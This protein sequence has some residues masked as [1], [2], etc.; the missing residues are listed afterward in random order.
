MRYPNRIFFALGLWLASSV[1]ALAACPAGWTGF[2]T[3]AA[4]ASGDVTSALGFTPAN[5][6]G[7][8]FTGPLI[9]KATA[10]GASG[11]NLPPGTAPTSPNNGDVW[12]TSAGI[13][14]Q[15]N[16]STIGPLLSGLV[17]LSTGVTGNLPVGNLNSGTG[18]SNT[19]FW[20]GDGTW[21][22]P[23]GTS[24]VS[25]TA[26]DGSIVVSPSPITGIGTITAGLVPIAK[27]GTN[28]A[29]A[30]AALANLK[31][32]N[33]VGVNDAADAAG[34]TDQYITFSALTA[35]RTVTLPDGT[36]C[37]DGTTITVADDLGL[38]TGTNTIV[39][40]P[41]GSTQTIGQ[42]NFGAGGTVTLSSGAAHP[43][44]TFKLDASSSPV[45]WQPSIGVAPFAASANNFLTG[46][47]SAGA[48]TQAQ[49]SFANISGQAAISQI[50]SAGLSATAPLNIA[51][52]G[53]ITGTYGTAANQIVEGGVITAGG[54]TG[55]ATVTPVLTY[56]AAGQ[57][58]A[59]TTVTIA[60]PFSAVTGT[61]TTLSGYG[62]TNGQIGP[63][64]GDVTTSGAASTLAT[65]NSNVGSFTSAN[66]TVNAKGLVTA[67]AN[68]SG[69]GSGGGWF[70][71][72]SNAVVGTATAGNFFVPIGGG[73]IGSATEAS[74]DVGAP[75]ATTV[76]KLSVGVATAPGASNS[77]TI[78]LRDGASSQVLTC[79]IS[80]ASAVSCVDNTHSFN[81][82]AGDLVDWEITTVGTVG[83]PATN[84]FTIAA[85]NGT[86][87]VGVT[88]AS[89]TSPINVASPTTTPVISCATC[90]IGPG[91]ST[92]NNVPQ[93]NS[94]DGVTLKGGVPASVNVNGVACSLGTAACTPG[95]AAYQASTWYTPLTYGG[96][97]GGGTVFVTT[98]TYCSPGFLPPI[99]V[100]A[101]GA[102]VF[103]LSSGGHFGIAIYANGSN[104][105][106]NGAPLAATN[107]TGILTTN[108][109][110][111]SQALSSPSTVS[112]SGGMIW[113]C[114]QMDN[115]T[116]KLVGIANG[117]GLAGVIGSA[118]IGSVVGNGNTTSI[119]D[120]FL[121][122]TT[123]GTWPTFTSGTS[124]TEET[125]SGAAH[126]VSALLEVSSEP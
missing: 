10:I 72:S 26:A 44:A 103:T 114:S 62:I 54:P 41:N 5:K 55:S 105:R 17:S 37:N 35:S 116:A 12:T 77:Y 23:A 109:V 7:D 111:I 124:W 33:R 94:S 69:G 57:I 119:V 60:P 74:V 14:V 32:Q 65:V 125:G 25:I 20:R 81:V 39:I 29:T 58:T 53:A 51:S 126:A 108:A 120:V 95:F 11:F 68:G 61:P 110:A 98:N 46:F 47:T 45:N 121:T 8:T 88:S 90:A 91:A 31:V 28:G 101:L 63:L 52:T 71:Y 18:A 113:T 97:F 84:F 3:C 27:G 123:F 82:T 93:W 78:T 86:S 16:G 115:T 30:L 64:T 36:T 87:G 96:S 4:I 107:A 40:R 106:P 118:T 80:G 42:Q 38:S 92:A 99:T 43:A 104:N 70:N 85:A 19:T 15:I 89:G 21:A 76:A 122:G 73:G 9:T 2:G 117:P 100:E 59:V 22:T 13:Y 48:I 34:C 83:L 24:G 49:P 67:A 75:S 6:A 112:L 56:N 66:I 79:A 50:G 102:N 1:A